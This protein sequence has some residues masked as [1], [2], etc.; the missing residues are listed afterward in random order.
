MA[1]R[2]LRLQTEP[3]AGVESVK[4]HDISPWIRWIISLMPD[5][6]LRFFYRILL[7]C[8]ITAIVSIILFNLKN[9]LWSYSRAKKLV[10]GGEEKERDAGALYRMEHAQAEA[11][12]LARDG[13]F[14]EAIHT[15]LLRSVGEMRKRMPGAI[16][17][18]L[19]SRE[20]L[21]HLDLS[22]EEREVFGTLVD[23]VEI[24]YFGGYEPGEDEY[25]TCR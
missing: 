23:S 3:P 19:T 9:N 2:D 4:P 18:S 8:A 22:P 6:F 21:R 7:F 16:A 14:A 10:F 13:S 17:A 5:R 25:L 1:K 24:S 15:L 11:D 12:D 20:L